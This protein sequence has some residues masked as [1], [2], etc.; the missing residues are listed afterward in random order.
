MTGQIVSV[1]RSGV[2]VIGTV[3]VNEG[4]GRGPVE[5]TAAVL[6]VDAGGNPLAPADVKAALVAAWQF[7]RSLRP[8][9]PVDL[10]AQINGNINL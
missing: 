8:T 1:V 5:Y 7:Q 3:R 2:S 10:S 9:N 4:D 6:G